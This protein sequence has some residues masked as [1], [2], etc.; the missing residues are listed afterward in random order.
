[1]RGAGVRRSLRMGLGTGTLLS[2]SPSQA[3]DPTNYTGLTTHDVAEQNLLSL[4]HEYGQKSFVLS[5]FA[6]ARLSTYFPEGPHQ[7]NH[8]DRR[9][10]ASSSSLS[11]MTGG[12]IIRQTNTATSTTTAGSATGQSTTLISSEVAASE[13]YVLY[14]R[15]LSF[16]QRALD[17]ARAYVEARSG[18]ASRYAVPLQPSQEVSEA[19]QW[20]RTAFNDGFERA[21]FARSK[22]SEEMPESA[23]YIDKMIFEQALEIARGAAVDELEN[24]RVDD[25]SWNAER[26][27]LAYETA[28]TMLQGLLDPGDANNDLSA[29]AMGTIEKFVRSISKRMASIQR[30]FEHTTAVAV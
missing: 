27:L 15:S 18:S 4:L 2:S 29:S 10:R 17:A 28:C 1:M 7:N 13:A 25:Q 22:S 21:N 5:E 16:L 9:R 19:I 8:M 24:N 11:S 12:S 23:Q 30:K 26:C 20:L 14:A 6:D 3:F